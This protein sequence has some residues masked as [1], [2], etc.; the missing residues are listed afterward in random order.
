MVLF[1]YREIRL[2]FDKDEDKK[3]LSL[4]ESIYNNNILLVSPN[5]LLEEDPS[6]DELP[7]IGVVGEVKMKIDLPNGK[8][9]VIISGINRVRIHVYTKEDGLIEAMTSNILPE[10]LSV[11]EEIAYSRSLFKHVEIYV[12]EITYMSN[13]IIWRN[14]EIINI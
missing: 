9:R 7:N 14:T 6:V 8:T 10:E 12:K 2:E 1:P 13:T 5:D 4:A 11:V 3:L